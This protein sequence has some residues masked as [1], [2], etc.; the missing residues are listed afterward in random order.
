MLLI[1]FFD[2]AALA[3]ESGAL[4]KG[5]TDSISLSSSQLSAAPHVDSSQN[6]ANDSSDTSYAKHHFASLNTTSCADD[7]EICGKIHFIL[8]LYYY[9]KNNLKI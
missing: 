6:N 8:F 7:R 5:T 1:I 3:G 4:V 2:L 9:A